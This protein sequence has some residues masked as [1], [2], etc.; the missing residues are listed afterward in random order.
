MNVKLFYNK[1]MSKINSPEELNGMIC[2]TNPGVWIILTA[3]LVLLLCT[4][5]WGILGRVGSILISWHCSTSLRKIPQ[6]Q[7]VY[8]TIVSSGNNECFL[9]A[10]LHFRCVLVII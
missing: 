3:L 9:C 2:V 1:H 6:P 10:V 7:T 8:H 4:L 5:C